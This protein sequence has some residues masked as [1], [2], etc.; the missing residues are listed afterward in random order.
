MLQKFY[1]LGS[2][3]WGNVAMVTKNPTSICISW[4]VYTAHQRDYAMKNVF[5]S[6]V[7]KKRYEISPFS[8]IE[9]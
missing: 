5:F 1:I 7:I 6:I 3:G 4:A 9:V 2:L 8:W